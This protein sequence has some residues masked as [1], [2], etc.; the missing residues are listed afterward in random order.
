M[1]GSSCHGRP[2]FVIAAFGSPCT[3]AYPYL[4][5]N[6]EFENRGVTIVG[7]FSKL[8][9]KKEPLDATAMA[10]QA[11]QRRLP[12]MDPLQTADEKS[13]IRRNMERD[14]DEARERRGG[15]TPPTA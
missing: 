12:S 11:R 5:L 10:E 2:S 4:P 7:L 15:T 13:T 3:K 9:G 14:L 8:F 6:W 1:I